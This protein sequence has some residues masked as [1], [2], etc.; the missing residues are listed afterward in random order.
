MS[1]EPRVD[2]PNYVTIPTSELG[3]EGIIGK[4]VASWRNTILLAFRNE[5]E[6]DRIGQYTISKHIIL[7]A[8]PWTE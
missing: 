3:K 5:G 1:H 4:V 6:R 2:I 8:T 7:E